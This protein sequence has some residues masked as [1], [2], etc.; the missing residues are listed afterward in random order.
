M[1]CALPAKITAVALDADVV[2]FSHLT[3]R[4]SFLKKPSCCAINNSAF[5]GLEPAAMVTLVMLSAFA[6]D[7]DVP[8]AVLVPLEHAAARRAA[9][10]SSIA[11]RTFLE[12]PR[13]IALGL[14]FIEPSWAECV[15]VLAQPTGGPPRTDVVVLPA[16]RNVVYSRQKL[17]VKTT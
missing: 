16:T 14:E 7:A 13:R 9:D 12:R 2:A 6:P 1:N 15:D 3:S 17:M 10:V 8:E 11:G 5:D 4:P